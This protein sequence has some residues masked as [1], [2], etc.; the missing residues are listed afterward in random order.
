MAGLNT[1][2][3]QNLGLGATTNHPQVENRRQK[4]YKDDDNQHDD[5]LEEASRLLSLD[6]FAPNFVS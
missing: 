2:G 4:C 6:D 3:P 1:R 5:D